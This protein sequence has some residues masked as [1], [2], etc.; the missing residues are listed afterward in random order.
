MHILDNLE[1]IGKIDPEDMYHKIIHLPEQV[2]KAY[3]EDTVRIPP[4][5]TKIKKSDIKRVVMCG[6]GGS[7]IAGDIAKAA[8]GRK[9]AFEVIK[10]YEI[11]WL[12][13]NTLVVVTSYSGDTEETLSCLI[14]AVK[15]TDHIAAITSGGKIEQIVDGKYRWVKVPAGKPPRTAIAYLFFSAMKI[16]EE[17]MI[18]PDH[19]ETVKVLIANLVQKAGAIAQEN[20]LEKNL[21]KNTALEIKGKIPVIYAEDPQLEPIA[22]RWKCQINENAKH[23]AYSLTF[24]EMNH[25]EIESWEKPDNPDNIIPVFIQRFKQ[26]HNYRKRINAVKTFFKQMKISYLEFFVEG[27]K[28]IEQI[29]SLIYL[30]DMVSFYLA[31]LNDVD[32]TRIDLIKTLKEKIKQKKREK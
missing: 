8:F 4:H 31:I 14:Q 5:L 30:G 9:I 2:M 19:S 3:H 11:P 25:N 27:D 10:D 29:F 24:P 21:A 32:P 26:E 1:K 22:Y 6:M 7:A 12:D 16:L 15:N 20:P 28:L 23:P 18:I 17:F 13:R